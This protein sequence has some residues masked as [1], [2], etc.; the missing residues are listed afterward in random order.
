MGVA[1]K[2]STYLPEDSSWIP[3][4]EDAELS[5]TPVPYVDATMLSAMM[6]I[7]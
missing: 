6:M 3:L 5:A 4:D 1:L 2:L 7:H